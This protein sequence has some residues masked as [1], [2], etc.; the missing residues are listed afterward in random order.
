MSKQPVLY[1]LLALG[2]IL[3]GVGGIAFWQLS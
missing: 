2:I 3:L 1:V